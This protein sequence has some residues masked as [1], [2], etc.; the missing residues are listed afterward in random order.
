M[1]DI[2]YRKNLF[3]LYLNNNLMISLHVE[4]YTE[5]FRY[6]N[7]SILRH[8]YDIPISKYKQLQKLDSNVKIIKSEFSK[9]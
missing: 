7:T 5:V 3:C 8:H 6:K 4:T 1:Q 2:R 9:S